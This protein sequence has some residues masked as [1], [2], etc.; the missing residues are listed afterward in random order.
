V[1]NNKGFTLVELLAVIVILGVISTVAIPSVNNYINGSKDD[2]FVYEAKNYVKAVQTG[3]VSGEYDAPRNANDVTIV[4]LN[5]IETLEGE[6]SPYG[7]KWVDN[8]CYV[9]VVNE[10][11]PT[12]PKYAYYFAAQDEGRNALP[13]TRIE[14]ITSDLITHEARNTMEVTVQSLAGSI[15]GSTSKKGNISGLENVKNN[16]VKLDWNVI[17]YSNSK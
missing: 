17:I 11:E 7:E 10:G 2:S 15:E 4:S 8:K 13:L 12:S 14:N 3:I 16:G 6:T 5:Y 9:A 1:K